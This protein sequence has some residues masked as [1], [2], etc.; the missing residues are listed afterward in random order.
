LGGKL[1][2]KFR[3]L[4]KPYSKVRGSFSHISHRPA[5]HAGVIVAILII[6]AVI[7]RSAWPLPAKAGQIFYAAFDGA[8]LD[9]DVANGDPTAYS[10][11]GTTFPTQISPGYGGAGKAIQ[12]ARGDTLY[13][14]SAGNIDNE[15]V[16]YSLQIKN[17]Y[18]LSGTDYGKCHWGP[19]RLQGIDY[20]PSAQMFYVVDRDNQRI[21]KTNW[22][23]STWEVLEGGFSDPK[24]VRY[25]SASDYLY[26]T[27]S[28]EVIKTKIDGTGWTKL[29]GFNEAGGVDYDPAS[30][31]LYVTDSGSDRLVKSKIDGTGWETFGT[32]G[33]GVN[34]FNFGVSNSFLGDLD[35]DPAS[36]FLYIT[37]PSNTRIVKAQWGGTGWETLTLAEKPMAISYDA[38]GDN[39]Y[40]SMSTVGLGNLFLRTKINGSDQVAATIG[41][42]YQFDFVFD[43]TSGYYYMPRSDTATISGQSVYFSL[44]RAQ[45][46]GSD[47]SYGG[48]SAGSPQRISQPVGVSYSGGK[49]YTSSAYSYLTEVDEGLASFKS[50]GEYGNGEGQFKLTLGD[51][52]GTMFYDSANQDYYI[53]DYGN[54]RVVRTK[55]D[56]SN[57]ATRSEITAPRDVYYDSGSAK[58]YTVAANHIGSGAIS[59]GT[60]QTYGSTG[61]GTGQFSNPSGIWF[62]PADSF[63]YIADSSN[64]RIVKT[65]WGGTGWTTLGGFSNPR[66]IY[67][68]A[69]N[70]YIYVANQGTNS[71]I[72]TKIDGTGWTSL[73]GFT[74]PAD[75]FYD[76]ASDYLYV[77]NAR[78]NDIVKTKIDGTGWTD[79]TLDPR[80]VLWKTGGN[81]MRLELD[82]SSQRL[83]F[84]LNKINGGPFLQS[85]PLSWA[86]DEWHKVSV[87]FNKTNGKVELKIDDVV[88]DSLEDMTWTSNPPPISS[89]HGLT[90][91]AFAGV[92]SADAQ[93]YLG[94]STQWG[95]GEANKDETNVSP[96]DNFEVDKTTLDTTPPSNPTVFRA[97]DGAGKTTAITD[98]SWANDSSPYFEFS[99]ATD[100]SS[101]VGSYYVYFGDNA[102]ADPAVLGTRQN[103][104]GAADATQS[105]TPSVSITNGTTYYLR[106]KARD[107]D[108]NVQGTATTGFT[109]KYDSAAP[110]AP[111]YVNASPS[112]C[113]TATSFEMSWAAGSDALSGPA[114]YDYRNGSDGTVNP[115]TATTVS[116]SPYQDGDN[117]LYVRSRDNAG[118]V[119]DW[120]A[121]VYCSTGGAHLLEGPIASTG[122][123]SLS[124]TWTSTK[125]TTS[126]VEVYKGDTHITEQGKTEFDISHAVKVVGLEPETTYRYRLRWTDLSGN[127]GEGDWYEATTKATPRVINLKAEALSPTKALIS[128]QTSYLASA[129][130]GYGIGNYDTKESLPGAASDFSRQLENLSAGSAYQLSVNCTT[131]DGGQ[132]SAG[133]NFTTPALPA[134]TNLRMEPVK[135]EAMPTMKVTYSSNVPISTIVK[136]QPTGGTALEI[137]SSEL[138][139]DHE[140]T[141]PELKDDTDYELVANGRDQYGLEA[142]SDA[143][144]FKTDID[145]RP[146]KISDISSE[147]NVIGA[148]A[149]AEIQL[150]ISWK[151]DEDS[152]SLVEYGEGL[153][154]EYPS[155]VTDEGQ[156]KQTHIIVMPKLA[157]AKPYHLRACSADKAGN[158][159]CSENMVRL[160]EKAPQS[161]MQIL[162][163]TLSNT[164]GWV[165]KLKL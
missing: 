63:F 156:L 161:I 4:T 64:N 143:Q 100:D 121:G 17:Q 32:S 140:V 73:L 14:E 94:P 91:T 133:A 72:K 111:E 30:G 86:N 152:T 70:D 136:Y 90:E 26:I 159:A 78:N 101:G 67:Y 102:S 54:A 154:N 132:F 95:G 149:E 148:G 89:I 48:Q 61:A 142:T 85:A 20:D 56:G 28:D 109:Y 96:I 87:Y 34:Q 146:P 6:F 1:L 76:S 29:S 12:A 93:F 164:F 71:I 50:F 5:F 31:F 74:T 35:Y 135:G 122:P 36:G 51:A 88:V 40:V 117:V 112:S 84:F 158:T 163:R 75:V 113:S 151:T 165:N 130:V 22:D 124:V 118:N 37:D 65:Q 59:S 3:E 126:Y 115:I 60:W 23:C 19:G 55:I 98:N 77:S 68:D 97:Y 24:K 69:A 123:S 45:V 57:W 2:Q 120:Q 141:L 39:I 92:G 25:D 147:S 83:K 16:T 82:L 66:G 137:S 41:S 38:A 21:V 106:V 116:V 104:S 7:V 128:W 62:N 46:N 145:T 49:I 58:V 79:Y 27:D 42:Q 44:Y 15:K 10:D 160:T 9:A 131:E 99:G 80:R 108:Y 127:F 43:T 134:I 110:N 103:H 150:V 105:Y 33:A 11:G 139:S 157:Q 125:Q 144:H 153:G 52:G 81:G 119:S 107:N 138:K 18:D 13:Y 47:A 155:K 53:A 129:T 162:L 8:N 114:G